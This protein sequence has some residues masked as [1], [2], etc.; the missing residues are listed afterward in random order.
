MAIRIV[1][2][3]HSLTN[4]LKSRIINLVLWLMFRFDTYD[5]H[6]WEQKYNMVTKLCECP[7]EIV[8]LPPAAAIRLF[9]NLFGDHKGCS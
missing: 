8:V 7:S 6:L 9:K 3:T 2:R 1:I 5:H 4:L